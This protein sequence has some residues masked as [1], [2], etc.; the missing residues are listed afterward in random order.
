MLRVLYYVLW[1]TPAVTFFVV[2]FVMAKQRHR[3]QFPYFFSYAVFQVLSFAIQFT[4]Y[5]RSQLAYFWSFWTLAI[6]SVC[7][8]FAVIY[9]LF[10]QIFMP[11]EGLRDLGTVLFRWAAAVLVV[12]AALMVMVSPPANA[13]TR[14][15][16]A[17]ACVV[18]LE[19]SVRVMQCGLVLL[20]ILCA[21]YL[22]LKWRHRVFGIGAAFGI[23]A[24]I[25]LIAIAVVGRLGYSAELFYNMSRMAAYNFSAI[26]FSVYFM[27]P[28]PAR[29]PVLQL[30]P[31][32]RWNFALSAAM[33]PQSASPSLPLIMGVVD[34]AFEKIS[35]ER[36]GIGPTHADQ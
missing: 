1:V 3:K 5:H 14:T 36:R 34:R 9:E 29:G 35:H 31:S 10:T 24:A 26:M 32:E 23:L 8:T 15:Q 11:F 17:L 16:I 19:R 6:L 7:I 27:R 25:D 22:G 20:M 33:H 30:A 28:E 13:T 2:A 21:P 4:T 18:A 12:A